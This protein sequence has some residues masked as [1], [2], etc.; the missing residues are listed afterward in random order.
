[1]ISDC[2]GICQALWFLLKCAAA[3]SA[4][5]LAVMVAIGV[6]ILTIYFL[7]KAIP[8]VVTKGLLLMQKYGDYVR[9]LLVLLMTSYLI[10][11]IFLYTRSVYRRNLK[12]VMEEA[13]EEDKTQH[14]D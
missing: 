11:T 1:M 9:G 14:E 13:D 5:L 8:Y 4:I 12:K 6:C 10:R 2:K 3:L 7:I